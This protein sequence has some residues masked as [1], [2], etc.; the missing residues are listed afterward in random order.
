MSAFDPEPSEQQVR[1]QEFCEHTGW[2]LAGTSAQLQIFYNEAEHSVPIETDAALEIE[3]VHKAVKKGF[4][5][6]IIVVMLL[7][8]GL[9]ILTLDGVFIGI[10]AFFSIVM[11]LVITVG[12]LG[13]SKWMKKKKVSARVNGFV[14]FASAV[15]LA[16]AFTGIL[17]WGV[18]SNID[19]FR[20]E[21]AETY[22]YKG[23]T[24][25]VYDDELPLRIEDLM[26]VDLEYDIVEVKVPFL[27]QWCKDILLDEF[28]QDYVFS[29]EEEDQVEAI[30]ISASVW[31]AKE[32]YQLF[33]W[34]AFETKY[35]VCYE[36]YIIMLNTDWEMTEKQM[37]VVGQIFS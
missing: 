20:K 32:A 26:E 16:L 1:F 23:H 10:V 22:E 13:I 3:T 14:T 35:F 19:T 25:E 15:I 30:E 27:Y 24:F 11:V 34:D 5:Y 8:L 21:P 2:K 37:A 31:G 9:T 36:N 29:E 4:L 33:Y 18:I 7:G 17:I 6:A 28:M 12:V